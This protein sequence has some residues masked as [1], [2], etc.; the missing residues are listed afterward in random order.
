VL[1]AQGA[2]PRLG[3]IQCS[4]SR[5]VGRCPAKLTSETGHSRRFDRTTATSGLPR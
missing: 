4:Y 2:P 1:A 3:E 5:I